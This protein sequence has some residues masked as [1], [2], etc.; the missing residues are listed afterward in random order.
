[1]IDHTYTAGAKGKRWR[2]K[3]WEW[4]PLL[5]VIAPDIRYRLVKG[6]LAL[7][8]PWHR[9]SDPL[10][11][12]SPTQSVTVSGRTSNFACSPK[13]AFDWSVF[14]Y[15]PDRWLMPGPRIQIPL[16]TRVWHTTEKRDPPD[17]SVVAA[18]WSI[19]RRARLTA[20]GN[21]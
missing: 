20:A 18:G 9:A 21:G 19:V 13:S 17:P 6:A 8:P 11:Y 2:I 1:M 5:S 3:S 15:R 4:D 10:I 7:S 12:I 16:F 14:A